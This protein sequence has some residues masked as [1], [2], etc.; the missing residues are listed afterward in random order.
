VC[1]AVAGLLSLVLLSGCANHEAPLPNPRNAVI[2]GKDTAGLSPADAQNLILA[3]AARL[4]VDHGFRYFALV[5]APPAPTAMFT[6]TPGAS[7]TIRLFHDGEVKPSKPGT[8]DAFRLL[9]LGKR[10]AG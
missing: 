10:A 8:W 4:T 9:S 5:N 2:S 7:I 6:L 1:L 3:K